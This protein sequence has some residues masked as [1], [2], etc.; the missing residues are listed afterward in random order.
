MTFDSIHSDI[1]GDCNC[2]S[3]CEEDNENTYVR[4]IFDEK[5][6]D[7]DFLSWWE[8]GK[9]NESLCENICSYKGISLYELR[10]NEHL[11]LKHWE[12]TIKFKKTSKNLTKYYCL[13]KFKKDAGVLKVAKENP[14][15]LH[16]NFYK[17]DAFSI[18]M[19]EI[20][21]IEPILK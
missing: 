13:L 15:L 9:R 6:Q 20:I 10:D 1:R 3:N 2:I 21:K 11:L 4:R 18:G 12:K 19:L 5:L 14:P 16:R 7:S 8:L 17:S